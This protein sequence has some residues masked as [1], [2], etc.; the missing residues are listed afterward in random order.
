[1]IGVEVMRTDPVQLCAFWVG[2]EEYVID[3]MR[4]E[5]ILDV[6]VVTP[7]RRAPS[8]VDGVV[9][10]RGA[11]IPVVDV[12][13]QLLGVAPAPHHRERLVLC[14]LGRSKVA[15][16]VDG[17]HSIVKAPI[18]SLQPALLSAKKGQSPH[19]LGVCTLGT[20]MLLMLDVKALLVE[21]EEA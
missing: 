8:F 18:D 3:I 10:L 2:S 15:L 6:P 1:M 19:V 9:N 7:V 16:R 13:R 11:V 14:K 21:R 17:V 5:E 4:V 12:R 20:R